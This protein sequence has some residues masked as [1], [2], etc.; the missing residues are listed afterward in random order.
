MVN[1]YG[2]RKCPLKIGVF[3]QMGV[4][5]L[6]VPEVRKRLG[7]VGYNPNISHLQVGYN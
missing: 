7:S 2:D 4:Y 6:D 5:Y 3:L 1:N